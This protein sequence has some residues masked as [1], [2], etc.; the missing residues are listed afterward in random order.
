[1]GHKAGDV[2]ERIPFL[3]FARVHYKIAVRLDRVAMI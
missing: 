3:M 2:G 1:M